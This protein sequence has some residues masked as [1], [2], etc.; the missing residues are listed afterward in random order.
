[1]WKTGKRKAGAEPKKEVKD[2]DIK[3]EDKDEAREDEDVQ[4]D[5]DK[6]GVSRIRRLHEHSLT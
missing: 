6:P 3:I 4:M 1:M 2:E 5:L